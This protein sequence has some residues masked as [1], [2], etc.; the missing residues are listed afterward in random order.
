MKLGAKIYGKLDRDISKELHTKDV[1][2]DARNMRNMAHKD[3]SSGAMETISGT[4]LDFT[5]PNC[6]VSG[7]LDEFIVGTGGLAGAIVL[8]GDHLTRVSAAPPEQFVNI[9]PIGGVAG[10]DSV[11]VIATAETSETPTATSMGSIWE[12]NRVTSTLRL[13]YFDAMNISQAHPV[14]ML[15]NYENTDVEKLYWWGD[16]NYL[17]HINVRRTD[18]A[19]QPLDFLDVTPNATPNN[20]QIDRKIHGTG[21]F[22][23]GSV[24]WAYSYV[25]R[26]GAETQ[27][28][29]ESPLIA[30]T[31]VDNGV[32][33][34]EEVA[35]SFE[36]SVSN[37]RPDFDLIRV[38][39]IHYT[40]AIAAPV[41]T[42]II[43]DELSTTTYSYIDDGSSFISSVGLT[44]YLLLGSEPFKAN[45][46]ASKDNRLFPAGIEENR[47]L[48]DFDTRAYRFNSSGTLAEI[49][50]KDGVSLNVSSTNWNSVPEKH[51]AINKSTRAEQA[52]NELNSVLDVGQDTSYYDTYSYRTDGIR[53]A[54]GPNVIIS[55]ISTSINPDYYLTSVGGQTNGFVRE[56]S[57][58]RY[59]GN[60]H[61]NLQGFKRD[62]IYRLGVV[63]Y[64]AFGQ[65]SFVSWICDYRIGDASANPL[66]NNNDYIN[67]VFLS[68]KFKSN[69][70]SGL[71]AQGVV[72]YQ[73]VKVARN[74]ANKTIMASGVL[75]I[76]ARST[77]SASQSKF[78]NGLSTTLPPYMTLFGEHTQGIGPNFVQE[79]YN[80]T[81]SG[82]PQTAFNHYDLLGLYDSEWEDTI[83][84]FRSNELD[85][86]TPTSGYFKI[87]N[88]QAVGSTTVFKREAGTSDVFDWTS[89]VGVAPKIQTG[90]NTHFQLEP[91]ITPLINNA[92]IQYGN[93]VIEANS[94]ILN[95]QAEET[96]VGI[97][98][99][100]G[101]ASSPSAGQISISSRNVYSTF[102]GKQADSFTNDVL[103]CHTGAAIKSQ[104][105]NRV[106]NWSDYTSNRHGFLM[107]TDYKRYL[108]NQY[109][110]Q[111]YADRSR[112]QYVVSSRYFDIDNP[113]SSLLEFTK[114]LTFGD[115]FTAVQHYQ[116]SYPSDPQTTDKSGIRD[117]YQF[118]SES[119]AAEPLRIYEGTF[120]RKP[121]IGF[122]DS[123]LYNSAYD[124]K[125]DARVLFAE[126]LTV[127]D[128]TDKF[129]EVKYSDAK[130]P[131]ESVDSWL[132]YAEG[133]VGY[134]DGSLGEITAIHTGPKDDLWIWQE[135]G[136]GVYAI[137]PSVI[138]SDTAGNSVFMGTGEVLQKFAY[139]SRTSGLQHT[140]GI[141]SSPYGFIWYDAARKAVQS[142]GT[143]RAELDL[144]G[145]NSYINSLGTFGNN[146]VLG[147]G[148]VGVFNSE[149]NETSL[150]FNE[151]TTTGEGV[152]FNHTK[153]AWSHFVDGQ[154]S[155]HIDYH[156]L[157]ILPKAG[158][159]EVYRFGDGDQGSMFGTV[160][161]SSVTVILAEPTGVVKFLDN[162][163]WNSEC[164]NSAGI[165]QADK[166]VNKI[167]IYNDHQDSG[168][169]DLGRPDLVRLLRQWRYVVPD[170][171]RLERFQS[172][173]FFVQLYTDNAENLKLILQSLKYRYRP[174]PIPFM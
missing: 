38:Y 35:I 58:K 127:I 76:A 40:D 137:N 29:P 19:N 30:I 41:I 93:V 60:D 67:E 52:A 37:L 13:L 146:P 141:A 128:T 61:F 114:D 12:Y 158:S 173:Y 129:N 1:Y 8:T 95:F 3:Q 6:T 144:M 125:H 106:V 138:Q 77:T 33:Y 31:K 149:T 73:F 23:S 36:L 56:P 39:R 11:F 163:F 62:E 117:L 126:P 47:F 133:N 139:I 69:S 14:E 121:A 90:N 17:R 7:G 50:D 91:L 111:T 112:N 24:C 103:V 46:A 170:A 5:I 143:D 160:Y 167:R 169:I 21:T 136:F 59:F 118:Y 10:R 135:H 156:G 140:R 132:N 82:V 4:S 113:D 124:R 161:P 27:I 16:L 131:G 96:A 53:G 130:I 70:V 119:Q 166:T 63:F 15:H 83:L 89:S 100:E 116:R 150:F 74:N 172:Q 75:G 154:P 145:I 81:V 168:L 54:E 109:G 42:L 162:L 26:N 34:N 104:I 72:G 108:P 55:E 18:L 120:T 45:A 164:Y 174:H 44:E 115:S 2:Y 25:N 49:F 102:P 153:K 105:G 159:R 78:Y 64:N 87:N 151:S 148:V 79:P 94:N 101:F 32:A 171:G 97:I 110:G 84:E 20:I 57:G 165:E 48:V 98:V 28:S 92:D 71:K 22:K 134:L 152:V 123:E 86:G 155:M 66:T 80:V 43:E 99:H 122:S 68:I 51:D 107:M 142:I 88:A 157:A 9:K 65:R 85:E 147:S